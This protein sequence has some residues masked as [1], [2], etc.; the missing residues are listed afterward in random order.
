MAAGLEGEICRLANVDL[1]AG[2]YVL[3]H[4][5]GSFSFVPIDSVH[6]KTRPR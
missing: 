2:V 6:L 5:D 1:S 3:E 4:K